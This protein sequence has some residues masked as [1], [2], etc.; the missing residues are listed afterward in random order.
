[1]FFLSERVLQRKRKLEERYG[2]TPVAVP[3]SPEDP[4]ESGNREE[5]SV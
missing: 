3:V 4:V 1:M 2:V 5:L